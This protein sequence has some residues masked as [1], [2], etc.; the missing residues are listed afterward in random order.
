MVKAAERLAPTHPPPPAPPTA[1]RPLQPPRPAPPAH[2][3]NWSR[4]GQ[5]QRSGSQY[6][7][8]INNGQIREVGKYQTG[9]NM[10]L[11]REWMKPV[12]VVPNGQPPAGVD[13]KMVVGDPLLTDPS[14]PIRF[15]FNFRW[16]WDYAGGLMT[17]WG[18]S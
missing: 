11:T 10:G 9:E 15:H 12:P 16:F 17:D 1:P 8:A 5:W 4:L 13:Y 3:E 6:E 18:G 14:T 2:P 7:Q